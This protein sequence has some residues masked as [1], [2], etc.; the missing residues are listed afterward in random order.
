MPIQLKAWEGLTPDEK[1]EKLYAYTVESLTMLKD[2]GVDVGIVQIGNETNNGMS[3][4]V[5]WISIS[6]LMKEGIKASREVFPEALTAVH[7]ANPHEVEKIELIAKILDHNEVDY[8]IFGAS[9]YPMW[10]GS[11]DNLAS[12][13]TNI[14]QTYDKYVMVAETSYPYTEENGDL[15]GNSCP[16]DGQ[17][18]DY[19]VTIQ[20]Q[21]NE[22]RDVIAA[23]SSIGEKSLGVF[24][25]EPA[26]LPVAGATYEEQQAVWE[27]FG[28][29]WASSF[30]GQYD[31]DDAGEWYGGSSWDN[32]ALFSFTG[33]PLPSLSVF[34]YVYSGTTK[35]I[36]PDALV[37]VKE[38][39]A[40]DEPKPL[41]E[42]VVAVMNDNSKEDVAVTWDNVAFDAAIAAGNGDYTIE[43][44]TENGMKV[45]CFLTLAP[46]NYAA[47][48]SF[49]DEKNSSWKLVNSG[50]GD[51]SFKL[52][53][54]NAKTGDKVV[55]FWSETGNIDFTVEQEITG[56]QAGAYELTLQAQGG[57]ALT[58]AGYI[59]V[60]I[61]GE[62]LEQKGEIKISSWRQWNVP[63][64]SGIEIPDGS[65]VTIGVHMIAEG[66]GVWGALDDFSLHKFEG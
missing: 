31:P 51:V 26:W 60:K 39:M 22:I 19:P 3:G 27:K 5:N 16:G 64:I 24:Y 46:L 10:H 42:T 53:T 29:G 18:L 55:H 45:R 13:L 11:A 41:P 7:F 58:Q 49:E 33:M 38:V 50:E 57:E 21:A 63:I 28:S 44:T 66:K 9:Y 1:A 48:P 6:K 56:L 12:V 14:S 40:P 8:D 65:T 61:G 59:Y 62:E 37:D 54:S 36:E 20:G 32:Q 23:A 35:A 43:G 52:D 30:A 4:E 34:K 15:Q 25:W 17:T 2:A 47:D